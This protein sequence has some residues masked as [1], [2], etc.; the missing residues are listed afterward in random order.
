MERFFFPDDA[1]RELIESEGRAHNRPGFAARLTTAR[2]LGV[3]PDDPADVP[4][5]VVVHPAEQ[6]DIGD[7]SVLEAYGERENTRLEHVRELRR[8][9][10]YREFAESEGELREWVDARARTRGEGRLRRRRGSGRVHF[11]GGV[12]VAVLHPLVGDGK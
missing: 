9:P 5:E 6:P 1:D 10:E 2:Y 8:V 3:F 11:P 4:P 7:P 12:C